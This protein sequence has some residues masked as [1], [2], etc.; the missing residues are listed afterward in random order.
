MEP[1]ERQAEIMV[2]EA[3]WG[4]FFR[5]PNTWRVLELLEGDDKVLCP[6]GKSNPALPAERTEETGVHVARYLT[7]ATAAEYVDE[8]ERRWQPRR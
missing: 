4:G 5:C 1:S 2:A 3:M 8:R 6:C 7:R